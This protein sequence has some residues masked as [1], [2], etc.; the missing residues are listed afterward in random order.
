MGACT[1]QI[2]HRIVDELPDAGRLA[3]ILQHDAQHH[4][5]RAMERIE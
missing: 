5:V 1:R 4:R 3:R 2:Q